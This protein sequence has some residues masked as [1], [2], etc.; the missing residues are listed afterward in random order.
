M[1]FVSPEVGA[2][3][4]VVRDFGFTNCFSPSQSRSAAH[5][6]VI[7]DNKQQD[8]TFSSSLARLVDVGFGVKQLRDHVHA[9][10]LNRT[11]QQVGQR[12]FADR[13]QRGDVLGRQSFGNQLAQSGNG[14]LAA[15][16]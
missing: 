13:K 16:E 8:R 15:N 7:T 9:A 11:R 1:T 4:C 10:T 14:E 6:F 2:S 5:T 12:F 3:S